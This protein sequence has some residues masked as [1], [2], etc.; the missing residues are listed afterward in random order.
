MK[1]MNDLIS[2]HSGFFSLV[3]ILSDYK[4]KVVPIQK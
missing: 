4:L 3:K 1:R 2:S